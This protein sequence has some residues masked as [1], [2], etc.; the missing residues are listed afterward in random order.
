MNAL[1]WLP[2]VLLRG[3]AEDNVSPDRAGYLP[4]QDT[5]TLQIYRIVMTPEPLGQFTIVQ[6]ACANAPDNGY[7]RPHG[8][9]LKP[10]DVFFRMA[11]YENGRYLPG[12]DLQESIGPPPDRDHT[13]RSALANVW[14]ICLVDARENRE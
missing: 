3:I 2:P 1:Q 12:T 10:A 5:G 9:S 4:V 14:A 6:I 13:A 8:I 7:A 11:D